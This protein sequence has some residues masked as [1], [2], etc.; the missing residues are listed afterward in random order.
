MIRDTHTLVKFDQFDERES[1]VDLAEAAQRMN[2]TKAQV[3][4]LVRRRA[5]RAEF[6]PGG[7]P[8]IEPAILTGAV[9]FGKD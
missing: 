3:M 4:D 7:E 9:S 2:L 8:W 5:L 6:T 1:F